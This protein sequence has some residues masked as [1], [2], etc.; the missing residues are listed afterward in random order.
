MSTT[1]HVCSAKAGLVIDLVKSW[2]V[3]WLTDDNGRPFDTLEQAVQAVIDIPTRFVPIGCPTPDHEGRCPGHPS[4]GVHPDDIDL[5]GDYRAASVE[6]L[7][8]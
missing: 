4:G 7:L 2:P 5:S 8:P 3:Q 1:Y 6:D